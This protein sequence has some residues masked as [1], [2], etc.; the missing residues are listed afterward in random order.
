ML[1]GCAPNEM[2]ISCGLSFRRPHN[3]S[4]RCP[5]SAGSARAEL[6]T[7][8]PVGCMRLLGGAPAGQTS[9]VLPGSD[10]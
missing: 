6:G 5:P 1:V 3:P 8:R 10:A 9:S 7:D 2:R 4:F